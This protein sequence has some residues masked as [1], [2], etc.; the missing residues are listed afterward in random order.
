MRATTWMHLENFMRMKEARYKK[1][2]SS[3]IPLYEMSE[4][5]K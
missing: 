2:T 1:T 4:T 5:G 3:V